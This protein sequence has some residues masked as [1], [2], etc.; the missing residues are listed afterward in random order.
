MLAKDTACHHVSVCNQIYD[1]NR[2]RPC[3]INLRFPTGLLHCHELV[4]ALL[5]YGNNTI[6]CRFVYLRIVMS[7]VS[8]IAPVSIGKRCQ[9]HF[10]MSERISAGDQGKAIVLHK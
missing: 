9:I 2:Y 4:Q 3:H 5:Q 1:T 7:S 6:V 10:A 8:H